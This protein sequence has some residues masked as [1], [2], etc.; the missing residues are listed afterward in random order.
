MVNFK[1]TMLVATLI[2]CNKT[3][4]RKKITPPTW[5][6]RNLQRVQWEVMTVPAPENVYRSPKWTLMTPYRPKIENLQSCAR[7]KVTPTSTVDLNC[8]IANSVVMVTKDNERLIIC[9]HG[10][11]RGVCQ[12]KGN[13][14]KLFFKCDTSNSYYRF[15]TTISCP[16][17]MQRFQGTSKFYQTCGLIPRT[18]PI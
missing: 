13:R 3:T 1:I 5:S 4:G 18:E 6:I 12:M 15:I 16:S 2:I 9:I 14:R 8:L 10:I 11:L 17:W 7:R